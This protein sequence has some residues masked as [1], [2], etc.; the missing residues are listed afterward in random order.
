MKIIEKEV[1]KNGFLYKQIYRENDVALFEQID[2]D[3]NLTIAYEVFKI[4]IMKPN[5]YITDYFEKFPSNED[6]GKTAW[7]FNNIEKATETY[8]VLKNIIKEPS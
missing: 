4:S 5:N 2:L 7:T 6:F 3:N 8:N 1:K